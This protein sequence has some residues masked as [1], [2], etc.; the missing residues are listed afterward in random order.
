MSVQH[1][2]RPHHLALAIA[3][4]LGCTEIFAQQSPAE[5][6]LPALETPDQVL[7]ALDAFITKRPLSVTQRTVSIERSAMTMIWSLYPVAGVS[8]DGLT[9]V[10]A[11][12]FYNSIQRAVAR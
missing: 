3:L 9:V 10:V 7:A 6:T 5:S 4:A 12:I 2:Y 8:P 11:P 1:K